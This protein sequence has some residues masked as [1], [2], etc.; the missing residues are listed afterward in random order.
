MGCRPSPVPRILPPKPGFVNEQIVNS[1]KRSAAE[2]PAERF[3][4]D[5]FI[6]I[7][8][9]VETDNSR[10]FL[11]LGIRPNT[12]YCTRDDRTA[13]TLAEEGLGVT[14]VNQL[15]L[16]QH[17]GHVRALPLEP[18]AS[19]EIGIAVPSLEHCSPAAKSFLRFLR[20]RLA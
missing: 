8:P 20:A 7:L 2:P 5:P 19:V 12:R 14:L 9:G 11:S 18:P 17:D 16:R 1:W 6:E 10:L 13:M 4:E 15:L 3:A